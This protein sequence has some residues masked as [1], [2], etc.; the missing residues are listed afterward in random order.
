M[1]VRQRV[2]PRVA[3]ALIVL[4]S[5]TLW[6]TLGYM[7]SVPR[8]FMD[9]IYYMKTAVSFAQGG[10]LQFEGTPW[11]YGPV[12]PVVAGAIVRLT[13]NQ[14]V[15]Y[16]LV[17]VMNA[18]LFALAA[19][20]IYLLS[21]RLLPTW[22]S[23]AVVA[24]SA[25]IP[26]TMYASVSMTESL[27]YLL[28]CW[29][30]YLITLVFERPSVAHQAAALAATLAAIATR[31]QL[32]ALYGGYLVG[33]GLLGIVSRRQRSQF[34]WR[35]LWPTALSI[36]AG[37]GWLAWPLVHG[38][39]I[40]Q[41]LGS[42][43]VLAQSYNPLEVAKWFAYHVGLLTLY[44]GV[45]PVVIAPI[46]V[47]R[48]W[49]QA[50]SGGRGEAA[51]LSQFAAQNLVGVGLVAAFASTPAGL[52]ILYD[53]YLFYLVPLWLIGLAVWLRDGM[54]RP[55]RPLVLGSIGSIVLVATLPFGVIGGQS[56][57]RRFEAIATGI[58]GKIDLVTARLPLVS[59]RAA[60]ILLVVVTVAVV[61]L[62]PR[63]F[64]WIPPAIVAL[65]FAANLSLS[66]RSAFVDASAYG[67][68]PP[69]TRTWV[70]D[71]IGQH[72]DVT[73]L[74]VNRTCQLASQERFAGLETDFFNRS[75]RATA[76]LG[77]E[78]GLAPTALQVLP[79]GK[80]RRRSG[81]RLTTRYVVAPAGVRIRGRQ[82]ATGMSPHLVLWDAGDDVRVENATSAQQVLAIPCAG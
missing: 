45:V 3:V 26:S 51:F 23:V 77:G 12:F 60:A 70:D 22:P 1:S 72:A 42:Y 68:S 50:E 14:E 25:A 11:G 48:W 21:R 40:G 36:V 81:K 58:W 75:V 35:S 46:V 38:H 63:R 76:T 33:L 4:A 49:K 27:G 43:S 69:G 10:G 15:A 39:G 24:L 78:G 65:A 7:A 32:V 53:R 74:I 28:S 18:L 44:L 9:E 37:L 31:P 2:S 8:F 79:D 34:P 6:A 16:E 61:T 56:W 80:L 19:V 41:S 59:L 30:I 64:R 52:G 47:V 71:R 67:L 82:L 62:V 20:P 17:K 13:P 5:F 54:P 66:W 29:A 73:V 57:F 55:T